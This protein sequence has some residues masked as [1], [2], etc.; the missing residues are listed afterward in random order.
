MS[1]RVIRV[2]PSE[3]LSAANNITGYRNGYIDDYNDIITKS[4]NLTNTTW[5]GTDAEAFAV[6][7]TAFKSTFEQM[8]TILQQYIDFLNKSAEAYKQAQTNVTSEASALTSKV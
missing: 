5:G 2:Q 7:I 8:E 4:Q 1:E 3:L 6:K